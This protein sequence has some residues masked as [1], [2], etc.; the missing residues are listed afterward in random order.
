MTTLLES[1]LKRTTFNERNKNPREE[2]IISTLSEMIEREESLNNSS[3]LDE[4]LLEF[5]LMY[6]DRNKFKGDREHEN[7]AILAT[8]CFKMM[9]INKQLS[10]GF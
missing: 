6:L 10:K 1:Y 5:H 3:K 7:T 2:G 9:L 4:K 8:L